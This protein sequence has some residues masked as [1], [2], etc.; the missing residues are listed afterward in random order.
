MWKLYMK[1]KSQF[2]LLFPSR[3]HYFFFPFLNAVQSHKHVLSSR[4]HPRLVHPES[5]CVCVRA[6]A[7]DTGMFQVA[8][9]A[10]GLVSSGAA[11][12]AKDQGQNSGAPS[13]RRCKITQPPSVSIVKKKKIQ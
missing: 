13:R 12:P 1:V 11:P 3:F 7:R 9:M 2:T 4:Q 10:R 5:V 6:T 8:Q